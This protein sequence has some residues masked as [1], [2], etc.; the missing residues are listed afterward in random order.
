[1]ADKVIAE[2]DGTT[3]SGNIQNPLR[4]TASA[5]LEANGLAVVAATDTMIVDAS[6][7]DDI[8]FIIQGVGGVSAFS[9]LAGDYPPS[10]HA[11]KG[12]ALFSIGSGETVRIILQAGRHIHTDGKIRATNATA[13]AAVWAFRLPAGFVGLGYMNRNTIP[14]APAH[15]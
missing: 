6:F 11:G 10:P 9:F 15:V 3:D 2:F 12:A 14:A 13:D 7:N 1:M 8:E 4:G 5:N